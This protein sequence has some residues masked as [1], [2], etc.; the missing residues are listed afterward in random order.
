[1]D[2]SEKDALLY[3]PGAGLTKMESMGM[4]SKTARFNNTDGS[5]ARCNPSACCPK[6]CKN[7]TRIDLYAKIHQAAPG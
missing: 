5:H 7:S 6:P 4:A 1:M 3:V 2:P